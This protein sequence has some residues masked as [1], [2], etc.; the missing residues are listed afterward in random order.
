MFIVLALLSLA[1]YYSIKLKPFGQVANSS[2]QKNPRQGLRKLTFGLPKLIDVSVQA[3][4]TNLTGVP[5][6]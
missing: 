5:Y 2:D 4:F 6:L 3:W 1:I